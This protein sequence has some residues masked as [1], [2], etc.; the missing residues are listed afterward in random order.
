MWNFEI[1]NSI[2]NEKT[3]FRIHKRHLE[4]LIQTKTKIDDKGK[5]LP[6]FLL[7]NLSNNKVKKDII[8][9]I[10]YENSIIYNRMLSIAE[11]N[12]PYSLY[13]TNPI[14]C[15]ALDKKKFCFDKKEKKE[16]I[17]K[18]NKYFYS[19]FLS[20]KPY[21]STKNLLK[22]ND[23]YKSLEKKMKKVDLYNPNLSFVSY[24][25]FKNN[26]SKEIKKLQNKR[27]QSAKNIFRM[28]KSNN[29]NFRNS[30]SSKNLFQRDNLIWNNNINSFNHSNSNFDNNKTAYIVRPKSASVDFMN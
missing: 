11:K 17:E 29:N 7:Y 3:R 28:I 2:V 25:T 22:Q 8:D 15:P 23:F 10:N 13:V 20:V 16:E 9:K 1:S 30:S 14:Y 18:L 27:N 4:R 12:S 5:P 24:N 19:R 21:Y 6:N 26:V